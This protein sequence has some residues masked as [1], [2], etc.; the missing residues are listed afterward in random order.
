ME[1]EISKP[2]LP[3]EKQREYIP[4]QIVAEYLREFFK[5]DAVI[6]RSSMHKDDEIDNRNIVLMNRG[7]DFVGDGMLLSLDHHKTIEV[8][9]V[10][11]TTYESP[12]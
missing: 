6:Y 8:S 12:F 5:C 1:I 2:I 11:F 3:H 7:T 10:V 4:T 9:N